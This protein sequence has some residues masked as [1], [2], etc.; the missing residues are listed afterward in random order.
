MTD[1]LYTEDHEWLSME[2]DD[3]AI[4][5]ISEFAQQELGDVVYVELPDVGDEFEAGSELAV[6]ESVKAAEDVKA[7]VSGTVIEVNEDLP[8]TPE[9][10][11]ESAEDH[12]WFCKILLSNSGELDDL[13]GEDE[14]VELVQK[15]SDEQGKLF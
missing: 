8:D 3:V 14:Y 7:P 10:V 6:V 15:L 1:K 4:V 12:G 13:M 9:I 11:N 2:S 5:G